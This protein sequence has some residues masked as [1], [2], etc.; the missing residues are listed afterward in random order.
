M[1]RLGL[2]LMLVGLV[3]LAQATQLDEDSFVPKIDLLTTRFVHPGIDFLPS[4]QI[5]ASVVFTRPLDDLHIKL[6][7]GG[8]SQ[9]SSIATPQQEVVQATNYNW[10]QNNGGYRTSLSSL[11]RIKFKEEIDIAVRP[12][13]II[14]DG[15]HFKVTF[16]P[17]S[18]LIEGEYLKVVL[19][20]HSTLIMWSKAF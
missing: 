6:G 16:L 15:A 18:A 10:Q 19:Q 12:H 2:V 1:L 13:A 17:H 14:I 7:G 4:F 9:L 20:P 3:A 8:I 11:F 5:G